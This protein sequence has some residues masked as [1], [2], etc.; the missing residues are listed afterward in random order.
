MSKKSKSNSFLDLIIEQRNKKSSAK[1]KGTFLEYLEQVKENPGI[2]K[3]AHKRLYSS[4]DDQGVEVV[5]IDHERYRDIFVG[6]KIRMY[7]Y[8]SKEFFGMESVI[9]KLMRFM[10][11]AALKGEE[12][13]Q[14]LL[15]MG[16]VGAGKSALIEHVKKALEIADAAYH[17]EGCPI[18]EEPLHLLP[19]SLRPQ[20]EELLGV[21]IEGD[22]CPICRHRLMNEFG[23][24][25][26]KFPV[27][28]SSFS[29]RGRRGVAVVPPM[30]VTGKQITFNVYT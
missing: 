2:V 25:Y 20:F 19:R 16:P 21:H 17:L 26:E 13:R 1:F 5:D 8:F 9:N 23:G 29:Q 3:L 4:I 6:E 14:V 30:I 27:T 12:S 7:D 11:S 15:L 24:E 22:L 28:Q 10:H 18:R